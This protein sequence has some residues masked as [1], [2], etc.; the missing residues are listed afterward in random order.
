M[1]TGFVASLDMIRQS[2]RALAHFHQQVQRL[3]GDDRFAGPSAGD[4]RLRGTQRAYVRGLT[5]VGRDE[6]NVD[7]YQ[8]NG[9]VID[10]GTILEPSEGGPGEW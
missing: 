7:V 2:D 5:S 3:N 1:T 6:I 10:L 4:H 8:P 9:V